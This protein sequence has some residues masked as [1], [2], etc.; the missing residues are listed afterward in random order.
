[1][2]TLIDSKEFG[3]QELQNL[4]ILQNTHALVSSMTS[5]FQEWSLEIMMDILH[6]LLTHFNDLVKSQHEDSIVFHI[7]QI[8]NNFESC[9]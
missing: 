9:I 3:I 5:N 4:N 2:K 7:D 1:M 6:E 8:F